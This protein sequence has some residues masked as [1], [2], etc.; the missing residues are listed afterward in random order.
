MWSW[1]YVSCYASPATGA[2]AYSGMISG[3]LLELRDRRRVDV[4]GLGNH[5]RRRMRQPVGQRDVGEVGAAEHFQEHQVG[6]AGIQDVVT[7]AALDVADVTRVEVHGG[8]ARA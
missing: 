6:V 3:L 7:M 4:Q 5:V 1:R 2:P 8:G